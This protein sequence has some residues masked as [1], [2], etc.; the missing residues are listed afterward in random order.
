MEGM[1]VFKP[2]HGNDQG[3]SKPTD[4]EPPG[5]P[6]L[7]KTIWDKTSEHPPHNASQSQRE[8]WPNL[9]HP[10]LPAERETL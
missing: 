10:K 2:P 6:F 9:S 4:A 1:T 8:K 5:G 7:G 3:H